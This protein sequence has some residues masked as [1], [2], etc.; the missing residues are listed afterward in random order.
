VNRQDRA[1]Q[2]VPF[3]ALKGL[4]EELRIREERRTRVKKKTLSEDQ[5]AKISRVLGRVE[6]GSNV[7]ICLYSKGHYITIE[8]YVT[9][10]NQIYEYIKIG[11]EKVFFADIY[12]IAII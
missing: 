3:D 9:E 7:A 8:G 5:I 6:Q 12:K 4:Q 2:F 11:N 10:I 1:K